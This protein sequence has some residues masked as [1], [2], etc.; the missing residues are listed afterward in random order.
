MQTE[1]RNLSIIAYYLSKFDMQAVFELGY[2]NRT[3]AF[4]EISA[5]FCHDNNYLKLRRDEFDVVTGS[6]RKGWRNRKPSTSVVNLASILDDFSYETL[7]DLVKRLI[8]IQKIVQA[9]KYRFV[10]NQSDIIDEIDMEALMNGFVSNALEIER[11]K[12]CTQRIYDSESIELLKMHYGHR[13]QICGTNPSDDYGVSIV[14]VHHIV[15]FSERP[16]NSLSNLVVLCPNHHR[17]I[18]KVG[19]VFYGSKGP[20]FQLGNGVSLSLAL[21]DHL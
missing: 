9:D 19:A 8:E 13:C 11:L 6:Y 10:G 18:H 16:D 4:A 20:S 21:N 15:P 7:T 2:K 1:T 3:I 5:L 14:E 17:L 12:K